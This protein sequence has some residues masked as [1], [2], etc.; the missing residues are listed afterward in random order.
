MKSQNIWR[1]GTS[2]FWELH[3]LPFLP[4][5][6]GQIARMSTKA[7]IG[8]TPIFHKH[9]WEEE[10]TQI[11]TGPTIG[12][13]WKSTSY[14]PLYT[15]FNRDPCFIVY[16]II[17][18]KLGSIIPYIP[19]T[20]RSPF[21][22]AHKIIEKTENESKAGHIDIAANILWTLPFLSASEIAK[23]VIFPLLAI[24]S[25]VATGAPESKLHLFSCKV[26]VLPFRRVWRLDVE[27]PKTAQQF[28]GW[29]E[30]SFHSLQCQCG[31]GKLL[32]TNGHISRF[33]FSLHTHTQWTTAAWGQQAVKLLHL[34]F[35]CSIHVR[36]SVQIEESIHYLLTGDCL[37][38]HDGHVGC[39]DQLR[40]Y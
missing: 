13:Q 38:P 31:L 40:P 1:Y 2:G 18:T 29:W 23:L 35:S 6:N 34:N 3:I 20:T 26:A 15:L 14:F 21:V 16:E 10:W 22:I 33:F 24:C 36:V 17:P 37:G 4:Y 25:C 30:F 27:E 12:E 19:Q 32:P 8:D 28:E 39:L 9:P 7:H 5:G 11:K